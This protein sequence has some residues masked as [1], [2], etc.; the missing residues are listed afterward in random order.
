MSRHKTNI[1]IPNKNLGLRR[2][3]TSRFRAGNYEGKVGQLTILA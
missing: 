1:H 2:F 3:G